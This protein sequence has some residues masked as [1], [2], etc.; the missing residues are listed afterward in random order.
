MKEHKDLLN[1]NY[2]IPK[3]VTD[4]ANYAGSVDKIGLLNSIALEFY[5][6]AYPSEDNEKLKLE[7]ANEFLTM[8]TTGEKTSSGNKSSIKKPTDLQAVLD[9]VRKMK[10]R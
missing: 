1:T 10:K 5:K 3:S 4:K 7:Y 8:I 6:K 2:G 9:Q